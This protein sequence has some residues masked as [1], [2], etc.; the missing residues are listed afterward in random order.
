VDLVYIYGPPG[1]GKLTV[2]TEL[3]R[4]TGYRL[5]HNHVSIAAI[6]PVFPYGTEPYQRLVLELRQRVIETAAQEGVDLI[7]TFAYAHPV[8]T[9]ECLLYCDLVEKRGGRVCFVRL[10][11]PLNVLEN[12]IDGPLRVEMHKIA[13]VELLRR[14]S[15]QYDLHTAIPG[16]ESLRL[17]TSDLSPH[18]A[19]SRIIEH[20]SLAARS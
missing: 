10:T 16:R 6:E 3:A 4:R 7:F 2:A 19:A 5:F 1:V 18:D 8:D 15:A 9:E 12:R 14:I 13:T 20:Y 11:A 17:D